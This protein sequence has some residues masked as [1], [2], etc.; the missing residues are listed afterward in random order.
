MSSTVFEKQDNVLT[1]KHTG[2]L[3]TIT[4][5]VLENELRP[6]LDAVQ[7]VIMD[8]SKIDYISSSGLRLLLT[9]QEALEDHGGSMKLI[10][11]S[12]YIVE[13]FDLVG[14]TDLLTI[15]SD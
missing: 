4:S 15:V 6:Y 5:P 3:D 2:R 7:E 13:I 11:V 10:H 8:F 12:D 9:T 14:F 1:V